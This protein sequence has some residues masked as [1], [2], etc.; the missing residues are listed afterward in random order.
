MCYQWMLF[1]YSSSQHFL[2]SNARWERRLPRRQRPHPLSRKGVWW[3]Q[4]G[5]SPLL[6]GQSAAEGPRIQGRG[7]Q[8]ASWSGRC[9]IGD[10]DLVRRDVFGLLVWT[11]GELDMMHPCPCQQQVG[12]ALPTAGSSL[13]LSSI[14]P[15]TVMD[16]RS[17]FVWR[18]VEGVS[19]ASVSSLVCYHPSGPCPSAVIAPPLDQR[20][21][22]CS[23][24]F[25]DMC[26][27][28]EKDPLT[29]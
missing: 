7:R 15:S 20:R 22:K 27:V 18:R 23:K 2:V 24:S 5:A 21:P 6:V 29:L 19:P 14:P 4:S 26:T 1:A 16:T 10:G 9:G 13:T 28:S 11:G 3:Q 25:L 17:S 12:L 8:A